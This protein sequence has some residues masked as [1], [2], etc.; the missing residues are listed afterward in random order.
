MA[1]IKESLFERSKLFDV[2]KDDAW[3]LLGSICNCRGENMPDHAGAY[4]GVAIRIDENEAAGGAALT[5]EVGKNGA[6]SFYFND[7]YGVEVERGS[8]LRTKRFYIDRVADG[9]DARGY[10]V[11]GV[12]EEVAAAGFERL[13]G[14]PDD[15]GFEVIGYRGW[16]VCCG[17]EIASA[18][19]ALVFKGDRDGERRSGGFELAVEGD[20]AL[21]M[22][23]VAGRQR[24]DAV[25]AMDG[26]C[27]D[28]AGEATEVLVRADNALDRQAKGELGVRTFDRNGLEIFK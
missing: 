9:T 10:G 5:V 8:S 6:V 27:D 20:D 24:Y 25:S 28:L 15:G 2:A 7:A 21:N 14:E 16:G 17:N 11:T 22:A 1:E 26:A 13:R 12:L 23:G 18:D 19:V 4:G 3:R